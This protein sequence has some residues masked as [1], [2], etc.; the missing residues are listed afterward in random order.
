MQIIPCVRIYWSWTL[1]SCFVLCSCLPLFAQQ[2]Q[3]QNY[4]LEDGLAQSQVFCIEQDSRGYIWMGTRGG[5]LSRYD[6]ERFE[7]YTEA[8]GL[9]SNYIWSLAPDDKGELWIGTEQ[10]LCHFFNGKVEVPLNWKST[11]AVTSLKWCNRQL[12]IGTVSGAV[13]LMTEEGAFEEL[14][15]GP[16]KTQLVMSQLHFAG[17]GGQGSE[18]W[19]GG[20][21]GI[22]R[23]FDDQPTVALNNGLSS[24]LVRT[25]TVGILDNRIGAWVGTYGGGVYYFDKDSLRNMNELLQLAGAKVHDIL[26]ATDGST[27]F[28]TQQRGICRYSPRDSLVE[29]ITEEHGLANNHVRCI[30]EDRWGNIWIGTSGGGVS[31]YTGQQFRYFTER[32]GLEGSYIYAVA[33]DKSDRLLVATSGP[34]LNVKQERRFFPTSFSEQMPSAK[35]KTVHK[36]RDCKLW[37]GT[38]GAGVARVDSDTIVI[39]NTENGLGGN[40]VRDILSDM[41]DRVWVA[42]SG[43]GIDQLTV[44]GDSFSI[45][46]FGRREGMPS[47]R[48]NQ[49]HL[50]QW[51]RIWFASLAGGVGYIEG[52]K[53]GQVFDASN[54]LSSSDVSSLAEDAS[55]HLWVGTSG[56]GLHQLSIYEDTVKIS[57]MTLADGLSSNICYL[58]IID[59]ENNLWVGSEKGLDRLKLDAGG[60]V[61]EVRHF[62][63]EEGFQG[64][65]TTLN[66]AYQDI[67]GSL[68]FGTINGLI[69]Y[70]GEVAETLPTLPV[71]FFEQTLVNA[72][73]F[74]LLNHGHSLAYDSNMFTFSFRGVSQRKARDVRYQ[75]QLEGLEAE[76][77]EATENRSVTYSNLKPGAYAFNVRASTGDGIWTDPI[78][79]R[80]AVRLPFWEE[81]WFLV[82][83]IGGGALLL[84]LFV[85]WRVQV[86]RRNALEQQQ[87]LKLEMEVLE[88]EQKALRLQMNPHFIFHALNSIQAMISSNDAKTA[89]YYLAKFSKL[90]RQTLDNSRKPEIPLENEVT[91]LENYLAIERFCHNERFDFEVFVDEELD[92]EAV[93]LPPILVQPFIENAIIHGVSQLKEKGRISVRFLRNQG[94]LVCE[95][96]DNGIGREAAAK[97]KSQEDQKHKSTALLITQERLDNLNERQDG[98][99]IEITDLKNAQGENA[100]TRVVLRVWLKE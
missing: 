38:D 64:V 69:E 25:M 13:W 92:Q 86:F 39:I 97:V 85:F 83:T 87:Q 65:E 20:D 40:Y 30:T 33:E 32:S 80:F 81:W 72:S 24:T 89:R 77:S 2:Y 5:G 49:L 6:G 99:S 42:T 12:Y 15:F 73:P 27:W 95:I 8:D 45:R 62:G 29:F 52:D 91:A 9:S 14:D 63:L 17:P 58:T 90:M 51:G 66:S 55:G 44:F 48:I 19:I 47:T 96:E 78:I 70:T 94:Y 76:W 31:K 35:V 10:G 36:D 23:F 1:T 3:F 11:D 46:H 74:D 28:A 53:V 50:D 60:A 56:S 26:D 37:L 98:Q 79:A 88:L 16:H 67:N 100:G 68:W 71:L 75:W 57:S 54:G 7:T 18:H 22:F 84:S 43:G 61:I 41:D 21:H 59:A 82:S 93:M 4:S 34:M